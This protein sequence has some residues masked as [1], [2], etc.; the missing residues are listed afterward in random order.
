MQHPPNFKPVQMP[1]D[2]GTFGDSWRKTKE[3]TSSEKSKLHFGHY[4]AACTHNGLQDIE[5][6]LMNFPLQTGYS[7]C[8]WQQGIKIMLLKK[9]NCFH[10]SKLQAILLFEADFNHNNKC[11]GQSLMKHTEVMHG[12]APEQY[13]SRKQLSAIDHCLNK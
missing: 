1:T 4:K 11:I 5:C 7:L 12:M 9:P 13:G 3:Y 10:V 2:S 8:R 6:Q